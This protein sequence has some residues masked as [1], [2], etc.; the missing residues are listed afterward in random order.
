MDQPRKTKATERFCEEETF[1]ITRRKICADAKTEP[2]SKLHQG[3]DSKV[4]GEKERNK[5]RKGET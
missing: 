1:P 4:K 5:G 3:I 2:L